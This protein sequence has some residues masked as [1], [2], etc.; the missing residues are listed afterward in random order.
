M[1]ELIDHCSIISIDCIHRSVSPPM[2]SLHGV[3]IYVA[4]DRFTNGVAD[5]DGAR[6]VHAAPHSRVVAVSARLPDARIRAVRLSGRRELECLSVA[7]VRKQ[8]ARGRP[9]ETGMPG[10]IFRVGR[11][12]DERYPGYVGNRARVTIV[13]ASVMAVI[14]RHVTSAASSP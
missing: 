5:C 4:R 12:S 2:Q 13:S 6:I 7:E 11:R 9:V 14:G 10:G 1:R 8:N 3:A